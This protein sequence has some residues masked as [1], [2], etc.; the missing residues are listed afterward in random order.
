MIPGFLAVTLLLS[1]ASIADQLPV[2]PGL[3]R[4]LAIKL[5]TTRADAAV[6]L[7]KKFSDVGGPIH[8]GAV[9]RTGPDGALLGVTFTAPGNAL[10]FFT[11]AW[12]RSQEA[13]DVDA[14]IHLWFNPAERTRVRYQPSP[15]GPGF[16]VV[17]LYTPLE[18]FL[19]GVGFGFG[20]TEVFGRPLDAVKKEFPQRFR[21][22]SDA[23]EVQPLDWS[24]DVVIIT[25]EQTGGRISSAV[26]VGYLFPRAQTR[27]ELQRALEGKLAIK[28]APDHDEV[29]FA[30]DP[31]VR[32]S[33]EETGYF[34]L[35]IDPGAG[36]LAASP[37]GVARATP[38]AAAPA[39]SAESRVVTP[40]DD[41]DVQPKK[42][43]KKK[44]KTSDEED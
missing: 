5:G 36:Y 21:T 2:K 20:G 9:G 17:D 14:P 39:P 27:A 31:R 25:L 7:L 16:L 42:K 34:S 29:L 13:R 35:R 3:P 18:L 43:K 28:G 11:A 10:E 24:T 40:P 19:G 30:G 12:G 38:P 22:G 33:V 44:R 23:M 26:A 6:P 1:S 32:L 8:D 4:G 15:G 37:H 41:E